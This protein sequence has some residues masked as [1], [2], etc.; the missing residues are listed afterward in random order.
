MRVADII[1]STLQHGQTHLVM[2]M[3]TQTTTIERRRFTAAE[4]DAMA[5]TGILSPDERVELL[6]GEIITMAPIGSRH[7]FCVAQFTESLFE[8]LGRRITL[9]VQN[10][11]R[12]TPGNE[13][14]PDIAVLRRRADGYV[15]EHPGPADVLLLIEV[16]DSGLG[17]DRHRN[18]PI[19]AASGIPEVWLSD[20]NVHRV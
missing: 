10:P 19:Y 12:L 9:R 16:A 6:A 5:K 1:G 14:E 2:I 4:F 20:L 18:L 7:A 13:P 3:V 11:I 17:F 15:S 8:T